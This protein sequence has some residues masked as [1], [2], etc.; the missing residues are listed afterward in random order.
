[1]IVLCILSYFV[2]EKVKKDKEIEIE[3]KL[4]ECIS[5]LNEWM[6]EWICVCEWVMFVQVTS[7]SCSI[8]HTKIWWAIRLHWKGSNIT[9]DM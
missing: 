6:S 1:M 8:I 9:E 5:E 4:V 7:F 2:W 3:N